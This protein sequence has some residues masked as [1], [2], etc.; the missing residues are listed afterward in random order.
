[1]YV[2]ALLGYRVIVPVHL[3]QALKHT[4]SDDMID[5]RM[6]GQTTSSLCL[7][8]TQQQQQLLF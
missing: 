2:H 5:G 6:I 7:H 3:F 8:T 4:Q 1:M